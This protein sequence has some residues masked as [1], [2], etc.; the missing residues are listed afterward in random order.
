MSLISDAIPDWL[1]QLVKKGVNA[2]ADFY[3]WKAVLLVLRR[4]SKLKNLLKRTIRE[5]SCS[6]ATSI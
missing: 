6:Q 4:I 1:E 5:V 2:A 3:H